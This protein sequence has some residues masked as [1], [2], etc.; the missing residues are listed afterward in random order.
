MQQK[1]RTRIQRLQVDAHQLDREICS[2]SEMFESWRSGYR[3]SSSSSSSVKDSPRVPFPT[4]SLDQVLDHGQQKQQC[5]PRTRGRGRK[6]RKLAA[7]ATPATAIS[8]KRSTSVG[9]EYRGARRKELHSKHHDILS[10]LP[11]RVNDNHEDGNNPKIEQNNNHAKDKSTNDGSITTTKNPSQTTLTKKR[12][13]V[14]HHTKR[15]R[16]KLRPNNYTYNNNR[17]PRSMSI[18]G[19]RVSSA[20]SST[21]RNQKNGL[22]ETNESL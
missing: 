17:N 5:L 10:K 21:A 3:S 14:N 15:G 12:K 22:N 19:T 18:D 20:P 8:R 2:L 6:L 7:N 1:E 11:Q 9:S 16:T 4:P 13:H